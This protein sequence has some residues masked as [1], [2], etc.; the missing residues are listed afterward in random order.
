M[1]YKPD[2]VSFLDPRVSRAKANKIIAKLGFQFSH[3]V[4]AIGFSEGIWLGWKDSVRL[5][6]IRSHPQFIST[7]VWKMPSLHPILISFVYAGWIEHPYFEGFLKEN[8]ECSGNFS[9]ALGKLTRKV[10]EWNKQV[11]GKITT[12]KRDLIKRIAS[13]QRRSDDSGC[14]HFNQED[15]SLRHE[16][17][18]VLHHE[19]LLWRQKVRCDWLKLGDRNTKFLHTRTLQRQKS[20][21][22]H[23]IRNFDGRKDLIRNSSTF[24]Y[25]YLL[26][27]F[28]NSTLWILAFWG[29]RSLMERLRWPF[30]TW[31]RLKL[32]AVMVFMP[33]SSKS[34]GALLGSVL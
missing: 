11:Y 25:F 19:E 5:E 14:H 7:R 27:V 9:D 6:V 15:L 33:L 34:S 29:N 30:L 18:N 22:I 26:V 16:L 24:E 28:L 17:E 23:A 21:R 2:I 31:P 3:R 10:K 1:E 20:N 12:R 8:W 32:Q 13:I 4:E